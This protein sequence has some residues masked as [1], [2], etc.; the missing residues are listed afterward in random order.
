MLTSSIVQ[1]PVVR[2]TQPCQKSCWPK[3]R[4]VST[5]LILCIPE[6]IWRFQGTL[7]Q[8]LL[9][10]CNY[11]TVAGFQLT[12]NCG[13]RYR[14]E[15]NVGIICANASILLPFTFSLLGDYSR[16]KL[17]PL[18][19]AKRTCG[20]VMQGIGNFPN[21]PSGNAH[22]EMLA[23]AWRWVCRFMKPPARKDLWNERDGTRLD[24]YLYTQHR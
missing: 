18:D 21:R 6:L 7:P 12:T 20:P 15:F 17:P 5:H 11:I 19:L 24:G 3:T 13:V 22:L 8:M 16:G 2:C 14:L 4:V 1:L 23:W 10:E 9:G